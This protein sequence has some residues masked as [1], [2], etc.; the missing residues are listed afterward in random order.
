MTPCRLSIC[1]RR[2]MN[3]DRS[4]V[5]SHGK[6]A[7]H[8]LTDWNGACFYAH[9]RDRRALWHVLPMIFVLP[10]AK[11]CARQALPLPPVI[12][13]A[14]AIGAN[15]AIFTLL[16]QALLRALPVK[17]RASSSCSACQ[18]A[19]KD[20]GFGRWRQPG[21]QPLFLL[22]HVPGFA[23]LTT[24]SLVGWPPPSRPQSGVS[25]NNQRRA[26]AG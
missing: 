13:L 14:L 12:T 3:P 1:E 25:W 24:R 9:L 2:W 26:N 11:S 15:T 5:R 23:G 7:F 19:Q 17:I 22:S 21:P 10:C 8:A 6:S 20:I 4:S 18:A 16:N